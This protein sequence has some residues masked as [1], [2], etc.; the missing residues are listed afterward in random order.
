MLFRFLQGLSLSLLFIAA[1]HAEPEEATRAKSKPATPE[2]VVRANPE[3]A[4]RT[5]IKAAMPEAEVVSISPSPVNGLFHVNLR[6]YEPVL[7]SAD[8]RYLI[9]GEMLEIRG[10]KFV[11]VEDQ[12]LAGERKK[13]L[14][15]L[16][17]A[18]MV[19]FPAKGKAKAFVYVFTDVDCGYCRKLHAEM[20]EI[21]K[22]GIEVRYLA[23]PRSGSDSPIAAKLNS[24]WCAKDRRAAMTQA[25]RGVALPPAPAVCK[26]PVKAQYQ[27][28]GEL[29]VRGT[30]AIFDK[31]GAQLG[32]Y[33]P[34]GE[35]AKSLGL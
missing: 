28:G 9:Q 1:A 19:I 11:N 27:M 23:F 20:D 10:S 7:M 26:S 34:A 15:A 13:A 22:R 24:V 12:Y 16:K 3:E 18:D 6:N 21:N 4:I 25:K 31:D 14:A 35:L 30:P 32:G 29:G 8:G 5:R 33:M 2:A 17:S